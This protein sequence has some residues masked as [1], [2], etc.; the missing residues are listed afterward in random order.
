[1]DIGEVREVEHVVGDQQVMRLVV[2]IRRF[3]APLRR[4]ERERIGDRRDVRELGIAGPHPDPPLS[5]VH[6]ET[7]HAKRAGRGR[8]SRHLDAAAVGIELQT[9]IHAAKGV[10]LEPA[11]RERRVAMR[12]AILEGVQRAVGPSID[13]DGFPG[14]APSEQR[15]RGHFMAPGEHVPAVADEWHDRLPAARRRPSRV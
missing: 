5:L 1:V 15:A 9:V 13:H 14:H 4:V 2:Q 11:Q 8:L 7:A 10:A 3:I 6:R 12:T